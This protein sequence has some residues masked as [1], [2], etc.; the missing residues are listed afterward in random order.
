MNT[1]RKSRFSLSTMVSCSLLIA[2]EIILSR[3]FSIQTPIVHIS[4]AFI[5]LV[6]AAILY[7]PGWGAAVG[8]IADFLGAHLFPTGGYFPGFTLTNTLCGM[9]YGL[10]LHEKPGVSF[11][12]TQRLIR[13]GIAVVINNLVWQLCLN[14]FWLVLM[15]ATSKGYLALLAVRFVKYL[16]MIPIQFCLTCLL[17]GTLVKLLL[18]HQLHGQ[19]SF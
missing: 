6:L 17:E 3:W 1:S 5:P 10:L 13:I 14:S 18:K 9:T 12:R 15:G 4:F 11:T 2:L 7:G 19:T 16:V 8:G